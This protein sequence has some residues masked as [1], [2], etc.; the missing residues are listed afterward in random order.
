MYES[1]YMQIHKC[2]HIYN[3]YLYNAR[4]YKGISDFH[5][6]TQTS[7]QR[8]YISTSVACPY[9][10]FCVYFVHVG[11][12]MGVLDMHMRICLCKHVKVHLYYVKE[13]KRNI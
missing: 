8:E 5:I 3:I 4:V 6:Q 12:R 7:N 13:K 2:M 1:V 9:I 10:Q 11:L